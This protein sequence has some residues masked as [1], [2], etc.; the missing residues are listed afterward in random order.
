MNCLQ[1]HPL[2]GGLG[3]EVVG[4]D[5]ERHPDEGIAQS[6]RRALLEH[7]LLLVRAT[8]P[9][10]PRQIAF[11]R[12]FG[13]VMQTCSPR[14]RFLPAF[15]EIVRVSN[16][17]EQGH[18]NV[19]QYWHSD[20]AYLADPT[21]ISIHHV[22]IATEDGHTLYTDLAAAYARLSPEEARRLSRLRTRSQ[23]GVTH[24]LVVTHPVTGR[25]SLY[26]NLDPAAAIIGESGEE[27]AGALELL[28]GHLDREGTCYRHQW[29]SGDMIVV[30][31]FA[32]AHHATPADP[33]ALRVLHRTAIH[34]PSV[35][36]RLEAERGGRMAAGQSARRA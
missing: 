16:R 14:T 19:G 7:G 21:A 31:N 6:L 8:P 34:G 24:P 1:L 27:A 20:G 4:Y 15:P 26:V 12:L 10:P 18:L 17:Q 5:F 36:W 32:V 35:W 22:V 11:T 28:R 30:D 2:A 29:R 25:R 9:D 33:R 23:T 13:A 3:A